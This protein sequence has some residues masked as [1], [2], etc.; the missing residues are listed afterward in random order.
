MDDPN[1]TPRPHPGPHPHRWRILGVLCF[2]LFVV[3]LDNT[4]LNVAIP[5]LMTELDATTSDVQWVIDAYSLVFAGLL[6]TAGSLGDRYGRR[7]AM[8][9]GFALF[10]GASLLAAFASG[11]AALVA[12]R[13]L[14]GAG[15]ALLMPGTLSIMAQVF[16][17]DERAKAFAVW[18]GTSTVAIAA[19]PALG[20]LLLEHF[21]WGSVFLVNVPIAVAAVAGL[22]L[23]VPE[24]RGPRRRPD[25]PGAV[26]STT[27][28]ASLVWA[29]I[30]GPEH[31]WTGARVLGGLAVAAAALVLFAAWQ[32]RNP[33]PMLDLRLLRRPEFTGAAVTIALFGFAIAGTL[34][35]LTQLLQLVLGYGPLKAG[36][37][38]IPVA[39][40]AAVGNGFGPA[41]EARIGARGTLV[42]GFVTVAA[43]LGLLGL[44]GPGDGY[45]TLVAGLV[46]FG[47]G[48]GIAMPSAYGTLMGAVPREDAGVGSAVNDAG[49]EL[50][51]AL[52][53]AVLGSAVA[54]AYARALPDGTPD[55]ARHSL[56]DALA[57]GDPA[58]A[59]LA[60]D[61]FARA[62]STGSLAAAGAMLAAAVFAALVLRPRPSGGGRNGKRKRFAEPVEYRVTTIPPEE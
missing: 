38:L 30:S 32:H 27:G 39:L 46:V 26:L 60:R 8:L 55:A 62:V 33:E 34:F 35:A 58:L 40:T 31:G 11:P 36:L 21:W 25:V 6:L 29:V 45:G 16:G 12:L 14:M 50:G 10:G 20:G 3:V 24:S 53:V 7:R 49:T 51:N 9:L 44:A 13:A 41:I 18:G 61:A 22:L 2:S 15:G 17:P 52:G 59:E 23:L 5:S 4:I 48:S 43:G 1:P 37:A 28:T 57:T 47:A 56:G 19:G 42:A 54:A